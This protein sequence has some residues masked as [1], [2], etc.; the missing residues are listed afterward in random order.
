MN[1]YYDDTGSPLFT[2]RTVL[3]QPTE[4]APF[5]AGYVG[6]KGAAHHRGQSERTLRRRA[7]KLGLGIRV[8]RMWLIPENAIDALIHNDTGELCDIAKGTELV[9]QLISWP[10]RA[11]TE[12]EPPSIPVLWNGG[13][14]DVHA[15][16]HT[17]VGF[18][19]SQSYPEMLRLRLP[20]GM[21][22]AFKYAAQRRALRTSDW[23]RQALLSELH[24]EGLALIDTGARLAEDL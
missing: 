16:T 9:S 8:G 21:Q 13:D 17:E 15:V 18:R 1:C 24:R 2:L 19:P 3:E 14:I 6:T 5:P 20:E 7:Q 22:A 11:S 10:I 12:N 4:P 23:I